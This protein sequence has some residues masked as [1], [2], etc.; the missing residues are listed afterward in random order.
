MGLL[1]DEPIQEINDNKE[2]PDEAGALGQV[3]QKNEM[4]G[5]ND[6]E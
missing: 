5:G 6:N 1:Q 2:T 3:G 4:V